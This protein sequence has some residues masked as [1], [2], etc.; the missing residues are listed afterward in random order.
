MPEH[1]HALITAAPEVSLEKSMQFIE[2]GFSFRL[3]S[4][5]DVWMRSFNEMQIM[6]RE[7]FVR[8]VSYIEK[9]PV[10]RGLALTPEMYPLARPWAGRWTKCLC[11]LRG[12]KARA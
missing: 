1:L 5:V 7:K 2:G 9:N 3:K 6:M 4:K 12:K 8:C 11:I 10:R